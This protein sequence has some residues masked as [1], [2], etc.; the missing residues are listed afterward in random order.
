MNDP[1][2][3]YNATL[4]TKINAIFPK[5]FLRIVTN[6]INIEMII[7]INGANNMKYTVLDILSISTT[8]PKGTHPFTQYACAKAAPAKPPISV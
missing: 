6:V 5:I 1:N 3:K 4:E 8:S 2:K 7:P